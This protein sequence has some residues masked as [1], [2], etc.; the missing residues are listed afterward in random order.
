MFQNF[1]KFITGVKNISPLILLL[2]EIA[3]QQY[4]IKA[5]AETQVKFQPKNSAH[6]GIIVKLYP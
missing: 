3:K 1:S 4:E 2:E 5:L 6:Y